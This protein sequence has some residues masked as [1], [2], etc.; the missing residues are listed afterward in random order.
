MLIFWDFHCKERIGYE[1][2]RVDDE[3]KNLF[4]HK[5]TPEK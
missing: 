5:N 1:E 2:S 3:H 4:L